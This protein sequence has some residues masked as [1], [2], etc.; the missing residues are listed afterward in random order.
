M[1]LS[2]QIIVVDDGS[3]DSTAAVVQ[4]Y[5]KK[6]PHQLHLLR[7]HAN[8]GKGAALKMGVRES[9]GD[10]V[11]I[12]RGLSRMSLRGVCLYCWDIV[13]PCFIG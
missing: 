11:L 5:M 1:L 9:I 4:T 10:I 2:T 8:R 7:L 6:R 13:Y 3:T 12:V